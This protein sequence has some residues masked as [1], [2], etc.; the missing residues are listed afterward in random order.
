VLGVNRPVDAVLN[1]ENFD[2]ASFGQAPGDPALQA[3]GNPEAQALNGDPAHANA[4]LVNNTSTFP[5]TKNSK[6]KLFVI[7]MT[8]YS[9]M[10]RWW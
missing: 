9:T 6:Q 4:A 5:P 8:S 10:R 2:P 7:T 3:P 1:P